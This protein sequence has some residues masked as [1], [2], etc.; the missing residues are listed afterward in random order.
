MAKDIETGG[1][2]TASLLV[3]F[4]DAEGNIKGFELRCAV[5]SDMAE[6]KS[7]RWMQEFLR[8]DGHALLTRR[9]VGLVG[10]WRKPSRTV[11]QRWKAIKKWFSDAAKI[12]LSPED[13]AF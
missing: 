5:R 1:L 8:A 9:T 11:G 6:Q 13:A 10:S 4:T 2:S 7:T 3:T 12:E